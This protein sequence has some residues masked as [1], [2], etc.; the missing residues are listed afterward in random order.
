MQGALA[1]FGYRP[2]STRRALD[3]KGCNA[4]ETGSVYCSVSVSERTRG[5]RRPISSSVPIDALRSNHSD[6]DTET[7]SDS[8]S[9]AESK[10]SFRSENRG[11]KQDS[12]TLDKV[13][14]VESGDDSTSPGRLGE[15]RMLFHPTSRKGMIN[16]FSNTGD[17]SLGY[18]MALVAD[19]LKLD[20]NS[21]V[22]LAYFDARSLE[23][24]CLMTEADLHQLVATARDMRRALPPLQIRKIEVLRDWAKGLSEP[25]DESHLPVW[26]KLTTPK[27]AKCKKGE[28]IPKD[29]KTQF[30]RDLPNLKVNLRRKGE[31]AAAF[32]Q[33]G[34]FVPNFHSIS[35]CGIIE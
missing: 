5:S 1:R 30:R 14:I 4:T 27:R 11:L 28:L 21:Q 12:F 17:I 18:D 16:P 13:S 6:T 33:F 34:K 15:P 35:M 31:H 8:D 2:K 24:F 3:K 32:G 23:D 29:W 22:M 20:M 7:G 19:A 26:V 25:K 9:Q 10:F